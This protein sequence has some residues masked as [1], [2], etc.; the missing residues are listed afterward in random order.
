M[1]RRT[2]RWGAQPQAQPQAH[3]ETQPEALPWGALE[4]ELQ[5]TQPEQWLQLGPSAGLNARN[6]RRILIGRFASAPELRRALDHATAPLGDWREEADRYVPGLPDQVC[7]CR[8]VSL[9]GQD[10]RFDLHAGGAPGERPLV[11]GLTGDWGMLMSPVP[12]VAEA[13]Q[14]HD[15][16]LLVVRRRWRGGYFRGGQ[17]D[18][19]RQ[20]GAAIAALGGRQLRP[21]AVLGTSAGGLPALVL[22]ERLGAAR[23][24]AIGPGGDGALFARGGPIR[25][26]RRWA[27]WR[28]WR[29]A[30][31]TS[32]LVLHP[33]G[34]PADREA[35]TLIAQH[36]RAL[37]LPPARLEQR[38][39]PGCAD[40]NLVQFHVQAG[41][42]LPDLL[43]DWLALP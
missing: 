10:L 16:D 41:R 32:L 26:L 7:P 30:G 12:Y 3:Q 27:R 4:R 22:A 17:G 40:H 23:G 19:L 31:G 43:A 14:R 1:A 24:V 42:A 2:P 38:A 21:R 36:Y 35:A 11:V 28:H 9:E 15:H 39:E 29:G 20:I 13:L 37:R 6:Q 18:W 33:A 34:H 25:R 5:R 8:R